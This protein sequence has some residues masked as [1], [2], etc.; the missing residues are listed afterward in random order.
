ML[1]S[2]FPSSYV[3]LARGEMI[4]SGG[5]RNCDV[6]LDMRHAH[7]LAVGNALGVEML[8]LLDLGLEHV[9]QGQGHGR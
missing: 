1:Y 5:G 2:V 6:V 9:L 8:G 7:L 3:K 4:Y